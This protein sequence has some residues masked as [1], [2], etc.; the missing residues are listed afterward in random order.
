MPT[1]DS[2]KIDWYVCWGQVS[3]TAVSDA[4]WRIYSKDGLGV[5]IR[6]S[7]AK[8]RRRLSAAAEEQGFNFLIQRVKYVKQSEL[9]RLHDTW[10]QEA[11]Q[12]LTIKQASRPLFVK[13]LPFAHEA[14]TR[15]VIH[16]RRIPEH[17]DLKGRLI[18]VD[19]SGLVESVFLD[20][21]A[22]T[23]VTDALKH[24]LKD[25]VSFPGTVAK[26]SLYRSETK[27]EVQ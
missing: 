4:M 8:L 14:E 25:T 27:L 10:T 7:E 3:R 16:D 23:E 18:K 17:T 11:D 24:F 15:V 19:A 20:P 13:R 12:A 26:S 5:R 6:V 9:T 2:R 21:R 22:P 1:P